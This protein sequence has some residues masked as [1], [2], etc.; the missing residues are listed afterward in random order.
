MCAARRLLFPSELFLLPESNQYRL[1]TIPCTAVCD[2][3]RD[4]KSR[5]VRMRGSPAC[6]RYLALAAFLP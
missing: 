5:C 3:R 1:S 2:N 6:L 4:P